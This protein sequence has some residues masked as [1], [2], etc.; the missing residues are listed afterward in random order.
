[1]YNVTTVGS[2]TVVEFSNE[3][4]LEELV[5]SWFSVGDIFFRV[6]FKFER[7]DGRIDGNILFKAFEKCKTLGLS[8]FSQ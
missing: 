8:I 7:Y 2:K 1:M 6:A 4:K 5:N 3:N